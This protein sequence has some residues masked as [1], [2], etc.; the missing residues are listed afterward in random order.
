MS[1][2]SVDRIRDIALWFHENKD[3]GRSYDKEREFV[4]LSIDL[5]LELHSHLL[6]DIQIL[7]GRRSA[8]RPLLWT[9]NGM[10][11]YAPDNGD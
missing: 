3:R 6:E 7:E 11:Y 10:T 8:G 9:P 4:H 5:L 1:K 2:R